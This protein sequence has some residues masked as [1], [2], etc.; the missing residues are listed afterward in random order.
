[1]ATSN[2]ELW[3]VL[4]E[5][6]TRSASACFEEL[7][8]SAI[9]LP[10]GIR[11]IASVSHQNLRDFL[12]KEC[13]R[14][15]T[16][17]PV[18]KDADFLGGSFARHTKVRPLDDIDIYVPLDGANL[19][20]YEAGSLQ[21]YTLLS[22]GLQW[23]PLLTPRWANGPWVS[24]S[25]V[26]KEFTSVLQRK[27]SQTKI[28]PDGQAVSVQ[29]TYGETSVGNGLGFDVVPCFSLAPQRQ[30]DRRLYLIPDGKCGWMKT[31]PLT[32]AS[33]ADLLQESHN[34]NFRKI[35]KIIKYWNGEHLGG[36]LNSYFIELAVARQLWDKAVRSQPVDTLSFG[37]AL[38]FWAVQQATLKGAQDSWITGAPKVYSGLLL[39][40]DLLRLKAATD[41][42]CAAWEDE[43][44]GRMPSAVAKWKR[45]LGDKFP[46]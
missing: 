37:V 33:I 23:N 11:A 4:L 17:P 25:K 22:D 35:V 16:F 40:G 24:S 7:L 26:V 15:S 20:Y 44:A 19:F 42:A 31:N 5:H 29:M 10:D 34:K 13:E 46:K 41:D 3:R 30:E 45:V 36:K 9:N 39:A 2:N 6:R 38:G 21:P 14:D 8:T 27:F 12:R 28:K 1:M 18:L 32:D 43:K